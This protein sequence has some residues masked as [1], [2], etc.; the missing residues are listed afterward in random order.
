LDTLCLTKAHD[1]VVLTDVTEYC[2][3][4]MSH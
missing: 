2:T 1:T 4:L 3:N